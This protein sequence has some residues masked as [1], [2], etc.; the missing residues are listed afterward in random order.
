L[1][2]IH[3]ALKKPKEALEEWEVCLNYK[4][5]SKPEEAKWAVTAQQKIDAQVSK[6]NKP[7]KQINARILFDLIGGVHKV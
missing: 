1:A 7:K 4:D 5:S 2:Q 3:E 6:K